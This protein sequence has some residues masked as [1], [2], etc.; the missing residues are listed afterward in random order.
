V[1][2][3]AR[4]SVQVVDL[5]TRRVIREIAVG[6]R[7]KIMVLDHDGGMLF[8][9]NWNGHSVTQIDVAKQRV[10]RTL[11][12]GRHPRGMA[13]TRDGTLF[14]ASFDDATLDVFQGGALDVHY[15]LAVCAIPRHLALSPD[16]RTLYISCF[17]DSEIHALDVA[18]EQITHRLAIGTNPKSL[19]VSRDGRYVY[20]ADYGATNSVS[21]VDTSDWTARVFTVPGM[22]R[23]SGIAIGADGRQALVTGWD[24]GHVYL[25]RMDAR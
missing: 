17:H 13:M 1:S 15:K 23:G 25:V 11:P 16:E 12:T 20:S 22:R 4:H 19:D 2:N 8:V 5:R 7:P 18:H 3:F 21:V 9:A 6:R 24:D 14:V 10:V